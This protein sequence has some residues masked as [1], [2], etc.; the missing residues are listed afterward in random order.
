M[1]L[2]YL[3]IGLLAISAV[4]GIYMSGNPEHAQRLAEMRRSAAFT[5]ETRDMVLLLAAI[6]IGGFIAYLTMTRR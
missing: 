1:R 6:G 4:L 3:I 5:G 2:N